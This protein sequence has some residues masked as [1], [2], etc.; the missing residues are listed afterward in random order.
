MHYLII[1]LLLL[2]GLLIIPMGKS[3]SVAETEYLK[4]GV[5]VLPLQAK[6]DTYDDLFYLGFAVQNTME[7]LLILHNDLEEIRAEQYYNML[8]PGL[9]DLQRWIRS[10]VEFSATIKHVDLRYVITGG[11]TLHGEDIVIGLKILDVQSGKKL[12]QNIMLDLPTLDQFRR[13]FLE[14]LEQAGIRVNDLQKARML[15]PEDI[16]IDSF[17]L[18]AKGLF[19]SISKDVYD[20]NHELNSLE[21]YEQANRISHRSYLLLNNFGWELLSEQKF[22]EAKQFFIQALRLNPTGA[23][24]IEGMIQTGI[25]TNNERLI[26][27]WMKKKAEHRGRNATELAWVLLQ[28]GDNAYERGEYIQ[29][30]EH[31]QAS[32]AGQQ[33]RG[34]RRGMSFS[35]S[36]LARSYRALEQYDKA[37]DYYERT[38]RIVRELGDHRAEGTVQ[39]KN[40]T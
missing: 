34:D 28:R 36:G 27:T 3:I 24:A 29:A 20:Q 7:N 2:M 6:G 35:L 25:L 18:M 21:H 39:D 12:S 14:L 33:E 17:S 13:H 8:F 37:I 1:R 26:E 38:L 5:L 11:F 15:W 23:D 22:A 32:L 16:S 9:K 40:L 19:V 10:D 31:F 4:P 30:I